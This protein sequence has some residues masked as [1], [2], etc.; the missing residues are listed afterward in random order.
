MFPAYVMAGIFAS[1]KRILV[2]GQFGFP[3]GS[4]GGSY[5]YH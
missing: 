4:G 1:A 2:V 3:Q 5:D